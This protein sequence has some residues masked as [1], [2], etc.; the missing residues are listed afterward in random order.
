MSRGS[1]RQGNR[2]TLYEMLAKAGVVIES[3]IQDCW[4]AL[5][6]GGPYLV[7]SRIYDEIDRAREYLANVI[8]GI[9]STKEI[10]PF[11]IGWYI[12]TGSE[13]TH[14]QEFDGIL[15]LH[16][17]QSTPRGRLKGLASLGFSHG[18]HVQTEAYDFCDVWFP[19][20]KQKPFLT[21]PRCSEASPDDLVGFLTALFI[22]RYIDEY[23]WDITNVPGLKQIML[24]VSE[25]CT[26]FQWEQISLMGRRWQQF[27]QSVR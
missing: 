1:Y 20:E 24:Q 12:V 19:S 7:S 11:V 25:Q 6:C 8:S 5:N 14:I 3:T 17:V 27:R 16:L 22:L 21:A 2:D 23:F 13:V 18:L 9:E 10:A 15:L 4:E 26:G